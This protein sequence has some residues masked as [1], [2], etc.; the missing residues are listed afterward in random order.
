MNDIEKMEWMF[1]EVHGEMTGA[2]YAEITY[3]DE[4]EP[5]GVVCMKHGDLCWSKNKTELMF[6]Y[7]TRH[8]DSGPAVKRLVLPEHGRLVKIKHIKGHDD[9]GHCLLSS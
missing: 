2:C 5:N 6:D 3:D 8:L 1:K 9:T 4:G 7:L